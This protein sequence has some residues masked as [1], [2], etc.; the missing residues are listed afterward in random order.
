M[1][2]S[3]FVQFVRRA[4]SLLIVPSADETNVKVL[5]FSALRELRYY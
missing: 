1:T 2:A 5:A 4:R 3:K